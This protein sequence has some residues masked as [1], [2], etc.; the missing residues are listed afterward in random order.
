MILNLGF[1]GMKLKDVNRSEI[2]IRELIESVMFLQLTNLLLG[3]P[4]HLIIEIAT[5]AVN[6]ALG[7]LNKFFAN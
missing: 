7:I 2:V 5:L 3:P 4:L 1:W 6:F